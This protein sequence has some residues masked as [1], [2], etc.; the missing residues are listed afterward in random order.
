MPSITLTVTAAQWA[1]LQARIERITP[2]DPEDTWEQHI[3]NILKRYIK[4]LW[5]KGEEIPE[6]FEEV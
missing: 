6:L 3:Q 5:T 2:K 4:Q 1:E